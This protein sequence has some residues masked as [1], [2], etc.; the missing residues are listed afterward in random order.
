M[1]PLSTVT[2]AGRFVNTRRLGGIRLSGV[3]E[4]QVPSKAWDKDSSECRRREGWYNNPNEFPK[5]SRIV[6]GLDGVVKPWWM[7]WQWI[8]AAVALIVGII[9]GLRTCSYPSSRPKQPDLSET[10]EWI[11]GTYNRRGVYD[12]QALRNGIYVTLNRRTASLHLDGC[13]AILDEKQQPN[14]EMSAE[15]VV[16]E[17]QIFNLADI[18]PTR[19]KVEKLASTYDATVCD[20]DASPQLPCDEAVIGLHTRNEKQAIKSHRVQE[21]P[22][23][24]GADHINVSDSMDD[25]AFIFVND[26]DYLPRL[27]AALKRGIELC[28]GKS[29]SF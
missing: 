24:T 20:S 6:A 14:L 4:G 11:N 13:A 1:Q 16:N 7:K 26:L 8:F 27:V 22:K 9:A 5:T 17:T 19:I 21:Y 15:I 12:A 3:P 28:G 10:A 29:S 25:S 18:D 2:A 23:L